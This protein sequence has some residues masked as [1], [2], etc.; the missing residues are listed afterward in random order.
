MMA[1]YVRTLLPG[2][3]GGDAGELQY[4]GPILALTHPTGVPVYIFVSHLWSKLVPLGSVAYRMN[5]LAAVSGALACAVTTWMLMRLYGRWVV[6]LAGGLTLGLGATFWGQ[7][8]IA[9][10]YAFNTLW[11]A[12]VVGLAL[13]WYQERDKP[14]GN[15]L[16]Y[17]L[18]LTYGISL[19]H[20]RTMLLFAFGFAFMMVLT[21]RRELWRQRRRTLICLTLVLLPPLLVYPI[22]LPV[23]RA[24]E[25]SPSEWQPQT[26]GQWIEWLLDRQEA[27]EAFVT[28][29][30]DNQLEYYW[31]TLLN[32]YT[33]VVAGIA[34]IGVLFWGWR[35]LPVAGFVLISFV[36]QGGLAANWRDND[37]LF[38][39]FLPSFILLV[40]AYGHGL[41]RL[42][43][44]ADRTIQRLTAHPERVQLV[45]ASAVAVLLL[46]LPLYQFEHTYDLRRMES[47]RGY[48]LVGDQT[49]VGVST[50]MWRTTLKA[51]DM[52][53]RLAS[54]MDRLPPN[55]VLLTD[56]EQ[57][58]IFWYYKHVEK[59]RTD[60]EIVYPVEKLVNYENDPR[61]VCVSR[62]IIAGEG[63]HPSSV[64]A[65]V[66]LQREP[67]FDVPERMSEQRGIRLSTPEG[68]EQLELV[69]YWVDET[70]Y[71]AGRFAP[72]VITWRALA[73]LDHNY[74]ISLRI[75]DPAD[76]SRV[77]W[78]QDVLNPVIGMYPT[79]R[80]VKGEVVQD[81][82]E[83][84][85][86]RDMPP[87]QYLWMVVVYHQTENGFENLQDPNGG[88]VIFGGQFEVVP[89]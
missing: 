41:N 10:K 63:W 13:V 53:E 39:Y 14:H 50:G 16:L 65:L 88:Q 71:E 33:L 25:L 24:R 43:D 75:V 72:L 77:I 6:A 55:A 12:L 48:S 2:P 42:W 36:L 52:G 44:M 38:T 45:F 68:V 70:V 86:P 78:Q 85:I 23:M 26:A 4:A 83:L 64:D 7:A 46:A 74:S 73:D 15:K 76:W 35:Q 8:V 3:V 56:W 80:W 11:V 9:D 30:I 51:G 1:V 40:Y 82:H 37:T 49:Q 61:E 66:C 87:G 5:L 31:D 60:L 18:S 47:N 29:G 22:F 19:L 67:N 54:G 59:R 84:D 57:V 81:Y 58:T 69:A 27:K 20:H 34:L 89:G 79:S 32:D 17:A 28:E 21:E 62:H